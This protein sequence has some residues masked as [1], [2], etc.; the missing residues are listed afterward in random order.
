MTSPLNSSVAP[1][2]ARSHKPHGKERSIRAVR[3]EEQLLACDV[4]AGQGSSPFRDGGIIDR[5]GQ[6]S[7]IDPAMVSTIGSLRFALMHHAPTMAQG[8]SSAIT[9]WSGSH[10]YRVFGS[11]NLRT[12][13]SGYALTSATRARKP[14]HAD[15]CMCVSRHAPANATCMTFAVAG[16]AVSLPHREGE[17][18][19][20]DLYSR[21]RTASPLRAVHRAHREPGRPSRARRS[22]DCR[23][24][25]RKAR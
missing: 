20:A 22:A 14:Q 24:P 11:G 10:T 12:L 1:T 8:L 18:P 25:S 16:L 15:S 7:E 3:T 4:G 17:R 23:P 21:G 5:F 2:T 9:Y 6:Y 13:R 19:V